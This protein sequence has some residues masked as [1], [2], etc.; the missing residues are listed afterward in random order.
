LLPQDAVQS[1]EAGTGT[2]AQVDELSIDVRFPSLS[3]DSTNALLR[4]QVGNHNFLIAPR[5]G[6]GDLAL[7]DAGTELTSEFAVLPNEFD[8][9]LLDRVAPKTV[10]LFA[11]RSIREQPSSETLKLLEGINLLRTDE[12]GTVE[13]IF[14]G[15]V[16]L[17]V[18][19]K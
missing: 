6:S 7:I 14:D 9:E 12:R 15:G 13:F 11:G 10:I 17:M 18:E 5:L 19:E 3:D 4:V 1:T 2:H 8:Q 16:V